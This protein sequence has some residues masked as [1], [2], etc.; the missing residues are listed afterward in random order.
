MT[1]RRHVLVLI[2][3]CLAL[4]GVMVWLVG[5]VLVTS[6]RMA[7]R[8]AAISDRLGVLGELR[9][10]IGNYGEQ[11]AEILLYGRD[12]A[13]DLSAVRIEIE[14]NLAR[15]TQATRAEIAT[16]EGMTEVTGELSEIEDARRVVELY[17][18]ID[19]SM[20]NALSLRRSD[21]TA[22]WLGAFQRSVSFRLANELQPLLAQAASGE[23][24]EVSAE[25]DKVAGART[26]F[27]GVAAGLAAFGL[28]AIL[29]LG[30][31]LRRSIGEP[32]RILASR[33]AALATGE[34]HPT[35]VDPLRGEF[36]DL[37][38]SL[39]Q[40]GEALIQQRR[41]FAEAGERLAREG[42][43]RTAQLRA[44]NDQLRE[45]DHRRGQF[46]A[47][48]S[49]E[50][51]TPLTILRGEADVA[52]RGAADPVLQRQSL[53]R[54]QGQAAEL[55]HLLE[56]LIEF[57]RSTAEDQPLALADT[58]LDE[59][60]AAAVQE[61]RMLAE[62]REVTLNLDLQDQGRHVDA[63]FRRLKQAMIIGLDN[64]IKHSPPGTTVT[65]TTTFENGAV[66]ISI[67]DQGEGI[68]EA[69]LPR[70]FERFFRGRDQ[71]DSLSSGLGIGLAI[72][73]EIVERHGGT[74][75]LG[76]RPTGGAALTI[77]VPAGEARA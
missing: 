36:A 51:R 61:G 60:V 5:T 57:A 31:A 15:L 77:W 43:A 29:V 17:H 21:S 52:L 40:V 67:L 75:A 32:L 25:V 41:Q 53:E 7:W 72:A 56:D 49:H 76:N 66:G 30:L 26:V 37:S 63:D 9:A 70:V 18:A 39:T 23:R 68:D 3:A 33:A 11:A 42:E 74:I 24:D 16:L 28:A 20:N 73:K 46:L 71:T 35:P 27:I 34:S 64:A 50:L 58:Q 8:V 6:D 65:V 14:R 44:A 59:I 10:Q 47:D 22:D 12:K 54:I 45:I 69:D 48:V 2:V 55:G 13:G 19:A 38:T 1:A 4:V 62:A